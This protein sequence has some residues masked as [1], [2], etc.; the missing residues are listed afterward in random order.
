MMQHLGKFPCEH[1]DIHVNS[2]KSQYNENAHLTLL[3]MFS[4]QPLVEQLL[5]VRRVEQL[6]VQLNSKECD[7]HRGLCSICV[8]IVKKYSLVPR[9]TWEV[10]LVVPR[11]HVGQHT[12]YTAEALLD[13]TVNLQRRSLALG[14][15]QANTPH[16]QRHSMQD[17]LRQK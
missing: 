3:S 6:I 5:D 17:L 16:H 9:L 12:R 10:C 7:M 14:L 13:Q 2:V 4:R 8:K 11:R 15:P 1:L